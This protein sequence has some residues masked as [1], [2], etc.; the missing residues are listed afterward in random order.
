LSKIFTIDHYFQMLICKIFLI[1]LIFQPTSDF[2]LYIDLF[3]TLMNVKHD[4]RLQECPPKKAIQPSMLPYGVM[5]KEQEDIL[6]NVAQV[7]L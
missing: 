5:E 4:V 7:N 1:K 6:K 2:C 3:F